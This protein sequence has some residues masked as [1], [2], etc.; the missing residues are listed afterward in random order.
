MNGCILIDFDMDVMV[1]CFGSSMK[2]GNDEGNFIHIIHK[3]LSA[4]V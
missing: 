2:E 1:P 3:R 4:I